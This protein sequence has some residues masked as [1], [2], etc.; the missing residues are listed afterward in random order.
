MNRNDDLGIFFGDDPNVSN[1]Q[2]FY[3]K[4]LY[5]QSGKAIDS[6]LFKSIF[7]SLEPKKPNSSQ[8]KTWK[9]HCNALLEAYEAYCP[10]VSSG[11][12]SSSEI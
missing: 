5:D 11:E 2:S 12:D 7:D 4:V 3:K 10:N 8:K 9:T 6:H 1:V